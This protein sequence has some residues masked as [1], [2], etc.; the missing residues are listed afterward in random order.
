MVQGPRGC[1]WSLEGDEKVVGANTQLREPE[2]SRRKAGRRGTLAK[3]RRWQRPRWHAVGHRRAGRLWLGGAGL[4]IRQ[5]PPAGEGVRLAARSRDRQGC[6]ISMGARQ[7][8]SLELGQGTRSAQGPE[9]LP[10]PPPTPP[11]EGLEI[12]AISGPQVHQRTEII[13]SAM[14]RG[15]HWE[16]A[17][18][19]ACCPLPTEGGDGVPSCPPALWGACR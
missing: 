4:N 17:P 7:K 5:G 12:L 9:P 18:S 10:P 3:T 1:L 6:W 13:P 14:P 15:W 16:L 11:R 2:Q 19:P 8:P